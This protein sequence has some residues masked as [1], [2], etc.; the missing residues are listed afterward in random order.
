MKM[1]TEY[2]QRTVP[3]NSIPDK[4]KDFSERI[5]NYRCLMGVDLWDTVMVKII[6]DELELFISFWE[7]L[8]NTKAESN[9]VSEMFSTINSWE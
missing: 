5:R 6:R 7:L 4:F 3:K 8:L 2:V 1:E 9:E